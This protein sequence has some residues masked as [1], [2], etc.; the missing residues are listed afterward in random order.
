[1]DSIS[2]TITEGKESGSEPVLMDENGRNPD[3]TI[4][5][6]YVLNPKGRPP[7]R[8]IEDYI[9][10][11][12]VIEIIEAAKK[13][14]KKGKPQLLETLLGYMFGR[15]RQNIGL[16][17]GEEGLSIKFSNLY[18]GL[19]RTTSET[20]GDHQIKGEIQSN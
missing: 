7:K 1:M 19:P 4:K 8:K 12:D 11:E 15:P 9:T 6:G 3:G 17:G 10:E 18:N 20:S 16:D 13:E 14:A 5:K 2:T